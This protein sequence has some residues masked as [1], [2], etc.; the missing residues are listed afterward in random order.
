MEIKT[1][2][3]SNDITCCSR[4]DKPTT[5]MFAVSDEHVFFSCVLHLLQFPVIIF[6]DQIYIRHC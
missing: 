3:D 6:V 1:E 2:A 4:C 5:G